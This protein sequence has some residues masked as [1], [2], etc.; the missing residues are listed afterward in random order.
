VVENGW[1]NELRNDEDEEGLVRVQIRGKILS[2]DGGRIVL[3]TNEGNREVF[4][5]TQMLFSCLPKSMGDAQTTEMVKV[6]ESYINLIPDYNDV[7]RMNKRSEI[8]SH[9]QVGDEIIVIG[10]QDKAGVIKYLFL[11]VIKC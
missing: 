4:I 6:S 5:D 11:A 10:D 3:Y 9:L 2:M 7:G 8:E 1:W